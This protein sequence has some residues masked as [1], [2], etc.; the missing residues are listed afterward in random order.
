MSEG[1]TRRGFV[2][3]TAAAGVAATA[4]GGAATAFAD[5]AAA[6]EYECDIAVVGSGS[7]GLAACVQAAELGASVICI[8]RMEAVGGNGQLTDGVFG[9]GS[10]MQEEAGIDPD[11]G[12]LIR[13]ELRDSQFR[14]SGAALSAMVKASGE[15]IDWLMDNGVTFA[16]V[17]H[18]TFHSFSGDF[19]GAGGE[20]YARPMEAKARELGV[21]FL[22]STLATS[23]VKDGAGT[24][25][26]V[27]AQ[28]ADGSGVRVNAKAVIMGGGGFVQNKGLMQEYF[29]VDIDTQV[30]FL[31][32]DGH[33]GSVI[34]MALDAGAKTN[35][36]RAGL[37]GCLQVVGTPTYLE[38]GHFSGKLENYPFPGIWVDQDC[39]RFVNE[40]CGE[41]NWALPD[42]ATMVN[43]ATYVLFD[44]NAYATFVDNL[45]DQPGREAV[46]AELQ[47]ALDK[48]LAFKG[49]SVADVAGQAGLDADKL[50]AAV[51][52]YNAL[53]EAGHD[54][55]FGK[56]DEYLAALTEAPYYLFPVGH[57]IICSFAGV[58]TD[59]DGR[60]LD[61]AGEPIP[62]LYVVGLDGAMLWAS[63]YTLTLPAGTNGNN[64]HSGRTAA[65]HAVANCLG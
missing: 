50:A 13:E 14:G 23:L 28:G 16:M 35:M 42:L 34:Q 32:L 3:G 31:G 11:C 45:E 41:E 38:G 43:R 5:G 21:T 20:H 49:G 24:I 10:R 58:T 59:L 48:G 9:A 55:D 46:D 4:V 36:G 64:V 17:D 6:Q 19:N 40:D 51:E 60:A 65:K 1:I 29:G 44:E 18:E 22:T 52:G 61:E 53:C 56:A 12:Q 8:E 33:D 57:L 62:G 63:E 37:Q 15:N 47:E 26:G 30:S 25:C 39:S 2:A 54:T 7:S 27:L